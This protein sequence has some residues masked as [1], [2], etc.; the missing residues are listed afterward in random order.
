[1][2]SLK[3]LSLAV[4]MLLA[5]VGCEPKDNKGG[6]SI[7]GEWKLVEWNNAAPEFNVYIEFYGD[8]TFEMYQQVWSFDYEYFDGQYNLTGD[9][10]TG[11]Y[12]N[13]TAWACGYRVSVVNGQLI[14]YS[15]EDQSVT[16]VY[17]K[18]TIPEEIKAEATAT[19]SLEVVPFL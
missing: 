2:K 6:K 18:C 14:M 9:V 8:K 15:Q 5:L 17:E 12:S 19:R 11:L 10:L 4:V 1:M 3:I 16:S 7:V 13:G